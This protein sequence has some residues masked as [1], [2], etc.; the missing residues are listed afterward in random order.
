MRQASLPPA[1]LVF[2]IDTSGS[3]LSE[4]KLGLERFS[5]KYAAKMSEGADRR[6]FE[7]AT[8]PQSASTADFR[9]VAR[10]VAAADT[11]EGFLR[12]MRARYPATGSFAPVNAAFGGGHHQSRA[13]EPPATAGPM[14][15]AQAAIGQPAAQV[16]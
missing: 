14:R 7:I 16:P 8:T 5:G 9:E 2:L 3:M 4:D 1:N 15:S 11:L 6:A 13:P 12:D 10:A